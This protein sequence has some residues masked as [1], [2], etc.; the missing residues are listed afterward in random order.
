V[1]GAA[2]RMG[3]TAAR[4]RIRSSRFSSSRCSSVWGRRG[5]DGVEVSSCGRRGGGGD[6]GL[7][8]CPPASSLLRRRRLPRLR[9]ACEAGSRSLLSSGVLEDLAWWGSAD[10]SW[11]LRLSLWLGPEAAT[12]SRRWLGDLFPTD[13][14]PL[15]SILAMLDVPCGAST[16]I[17]AIKPRLVL[18]V[19]W[20]HLLLLRRSFGGA[21]GWMR[22]VMRWLSSWILEGFFVIFFF[23][24]VLFALFPGQVVGM[25]P[26]CVCAC[27]LCISFL[28]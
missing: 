26:D 4:R 14:L 19:D 21:G 25:F 2:A 15:F 5:I 22:Q 6:H 1:S 8:F 11:C 10:G 20:P 23:S 16:Q 9:E 24:R 28:V 12:T 18:A 3:T 7:D 27:H 17:A 13:V